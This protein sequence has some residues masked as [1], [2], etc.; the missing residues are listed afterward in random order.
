MSGNV[1]P[2]LREVLA[3]LESEIP[4]WQCAT[5]SIAELGGGLTNRSFRIDVADATYVLRIPGPSTE[6]LAIDRHNEIHNTQIAAQAGVGPGVVHHLADWGVMVLEFIEG[7]TLSTE[8]LA[9]AEMTPRLAQLLQK[10]HRAPRFL[11]DF[12]TGRVLQQYRQVLAGRGWA[13][14]TGARERMKTVEAVIAAVGRNGQ[15]TV[16]C[17][18][19]LLPEN[20]IDDGARLW[21]V[22]FEL[23]GNSD[24]YSEL[25]NVCQELEY[26]A[27]GAA[28]LCQ[29]YF[30]AADERL[31]ARVGL[32]M[33]LSDVC[34]A[35]WGAIQMAISSREF[36][37]E[38]YAQRRF[39]RAA[40]KLDSD[41]LPKWLALV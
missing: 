9:T 35:L 6:L 10:L 20:V 21:M 24:P 32:Y 5:I 25:G 4:A 8:T 34:W 11:R 23:S 14:P 41:M 38:A 27:A 18:N 31:L 12:D 40:E 33:I 29:A 30:G 26:D 1:E 2:S 17:H 19:D 7:Q 36:D 3:R 28:A 22:D 37:F 15:A 13:L 39:D 16:A